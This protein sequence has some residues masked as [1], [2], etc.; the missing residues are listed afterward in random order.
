MQQIILQQY[1]L[2]LRH[3]AQ[4]D[5]EVEDEQLSRKINAQNE[6]IQIVITMANVEKNQK[7]LHE[8]RLHEVFMDQQ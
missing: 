8:V 1:H 2:K 6:I 7:C 5:D 4:D 3:Q